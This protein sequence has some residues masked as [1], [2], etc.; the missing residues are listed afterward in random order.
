MTLAR[1]PQVQAWPPQAFQESS[2]KREIFTGAAVASLALMSGLA[3]ANGCAKGAAVGAVGGHIAGHHA[4]AGAAAGCAVGHHEANKKEKETAATDQ[5]KSAPPQ[6]SKSQAPTTTP[7]SPDIKLGGDET[8]HRSSTKSREWVTG[9]FFDRDRVERVRGD[10]TARDQ[11]TGRRQGRRA[12]N[13]HRERRS[14][15]WDSVS[16]SPARSARA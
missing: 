9:S 12:S 13:G 8:R 10:L 4:V 6:S 5:A 1:T 11:R 3:S 14:K 15:F 16:S 2:M 7:P